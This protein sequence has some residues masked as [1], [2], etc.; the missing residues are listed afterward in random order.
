M[1]NLSAPRI[2]TTELARNL[3]SIIDQVRVARSRL[4][5]TRGNQAVAQ[6]IPVTGNGATL[7]DLARLVQ[8]HHLDCAEQ[9]AFS[10][11]LRVIREAAIVPESAW[12]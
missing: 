12:D 1:S 3:A 7:A 9:R 2:S 5:I 8:R 6:L 4:V 10:E 11:D